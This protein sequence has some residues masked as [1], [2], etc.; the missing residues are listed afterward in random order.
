MV[1]SRRQGPT[2][3]WHIFMLHLEFW[4]PHCQTF[5][6]AAHSDEDSPALMV[7]AIQWGR[8]KKI[9]HRHKDS[10]YWGKKITHPTLGY[11]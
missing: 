3:Y 6:L 7:L 11:I 9:H 10:R 5:S 2:Q 8:Q 1:P 4:R